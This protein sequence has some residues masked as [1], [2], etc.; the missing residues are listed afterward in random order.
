MNDKLEDLKKTIKQFAVER[1]WEQFHTLKNTATSI[2]VEAGELLEYFQWD[3]LKLENMSA[4]KKEQIADEIADVFIYLIM[5]SDKMDIDLI[6]A[7]FKKIKKNVEK[8][9]KDKVAGSSK[10]YTEY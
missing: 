2:S 5:M 4:E 10:K 6:E 7:S 9:P 3:D 1:D 8:Y